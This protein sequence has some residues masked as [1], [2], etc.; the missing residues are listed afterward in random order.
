MVNICMLN[1]MHFHSISFI[2]FYTSFH[3][4]PFIHLFIQSLVIG[5]L[6]LLSYART[7]WFMII[8]VSLCPLCERHHMHLYQSSSVMS[9][10]YDLFSSSLFVRLWLWLPVHF[11]SRPWCLRCC[12]QWHNIR[13]ATRTASLTQ[14]HTNDGQMIMLNKH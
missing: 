1:W 11:P 13:E 3:V 5:L 2:I 10:F 7:L 9:Y 4:P 8:Y 12:C 14:V 6:A